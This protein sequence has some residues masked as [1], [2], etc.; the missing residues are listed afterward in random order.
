MLRE[1]F[2]GFRKED[3]PLL[4]GL[5]A[6]APQSYLGVGQIVNFDETVLRMLRK[7]QVKPDFRVFSLKKNTDP[8][9]PTT[10]PDAAPAVSM[11]STAPPSLPA[12]SW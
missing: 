3:D 11:A 8:T 6:T 1:M 5:M 9:Y 2:R 7:K 12:A 10:E 4:G